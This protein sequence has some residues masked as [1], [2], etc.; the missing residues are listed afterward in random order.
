MTVRIDVNYG[1]SCTETA[2]L[3]IFQPEQR[4]TFFNP[5]SSRLTSVSHVPVH[6]MLT[7]LGGASAFGAGSTTTPFQI[8][9]QSFIIASRVTKVPSKLNFLYVDTFL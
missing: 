6:V 5:T 8:C 2:F 7:V 9:M 3:S 1:N 4:W